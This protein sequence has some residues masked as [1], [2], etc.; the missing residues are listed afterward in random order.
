MNESLNERALWMLRNF[1]KMSSLDFCDIWWWQLATIDEID[2]N[3][4]D[5]HDNDDGD[6]C[7]PQFWPQCHQ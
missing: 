2:I 7:Q 4:D 6:D 5:D 1:K 3:N